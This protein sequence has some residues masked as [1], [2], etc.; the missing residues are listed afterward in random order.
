MAEP[1]GFTLP[2]QLIW[3]GVL[4]CITQSAIFS[5]LNLACFSISRLRLEIEASNG[6]AA[7]QKVLELRQNSNLLLA[8]V[9]WG[10][11]AI[12]VLLTIL[13]NS[14]M[15][16]LASFFFSTFVITICG[17]ILPQAYFSRH[18]LKMASLLNPV[19]R[20]YRL[21]LFPVNRPTAL[22]LDLWLGKESIH[23]MRERDLRQLLHRHIDASESE[24]DVVEGIGFPLFLFLSLLY[25]SYL[26]SG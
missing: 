20:F 23:F 4:F 2:P 8:T 16:G 24:L 6:N 5:G 13:S 7:A 10:N 17:E 3:G 21:L 9:L 11:V 14:V 15:F 22:L 25:P 12:N 26:Q 18:A 19:L 1:L